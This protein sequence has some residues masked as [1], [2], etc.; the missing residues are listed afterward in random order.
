MAKN[1]EKA[2]IYIESS[3]YVSRIFW[4]YNDENPMGDLIGELKYQQIVDS[5]KIMFTKGAPFPSSMFN[6]LGT[7]IKKVVKNHF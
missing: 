4:Y 6:K 7:P 2:S 3:D 1:V 5:D